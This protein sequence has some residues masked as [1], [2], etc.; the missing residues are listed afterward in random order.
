MTG[1]ASL[2]VRFMAKL[3]R[4]VVEMGINVLRLD[5]NSTLNE[6]VALYRKAGWSEIPRFNEEPYPDLL[7]E[8]WLSLI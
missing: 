2:S 1:L 4:I 7:F 3:E 8:K 5:A 6:G